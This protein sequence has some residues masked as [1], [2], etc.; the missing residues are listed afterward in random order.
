MAE[1]DIEKYLSGRIEDQI[2]Y[3]GRKA[4]E[5][6]RRFRRLAV[7]TIGATALTPLLL[8]I[9]RVF[10]PDTDETP[11]QIVLGILPIVVSVVAAIATVSLSA[12]KH[13]EAWIA[14]R[15]V[16]E[17][18]R[19]EEQLFRHCAGPYARAKDPQVLF[20]ERAEALME[21]EGKEWQHLHAGNSGLP[22][23]DSIS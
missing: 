10:A 2:S 12:F 23:G 20:V 11:L 6:Q 16:C 1:S 18:L 19:R 13:K 17:A 22:R 14:H 3:H 15:S 7:L 21:A 9:A 4:A 5:S 8:A